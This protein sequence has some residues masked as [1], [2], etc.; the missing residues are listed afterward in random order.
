MT[1]ILGAVS[2]AVGVALGAFGSH[3]LKSQLTPDMLA[4]FE[5]GVRYQMY[6]AFGMMITAFAASLFDSDRVGG[7]A[8]AAWGF[9]L[10]TVFFSTSL[11]LLSVF[12]MTWLGAITPIGGVGFLVG[13]IALVVAVFRGR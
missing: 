3:G 1:F 11:Y 12:G 13:W 4:I 6:H 9:G 8:V 7:F 2:A 10:G 5:T